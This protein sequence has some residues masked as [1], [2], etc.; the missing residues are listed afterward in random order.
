MIRVVFLLQREFSEECVFNEMIEENHYNSYSSS[1]YSNPRRT[2]YLGLNKKGQG[3]RVMTRGG[4]LGRQS[5][6]A[7]VLT[8][9]VQWQA[10]NSTC[11][12]DQPKAARA[13]PPRCRLRLRRPRRRK[14]K[15]CKDEESCMRKRK[16][17]LRIRH[18]KHRTVT[19]EEEED[20]EE[21]TMTTE[22]EEEDH[23]MDSSE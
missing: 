5:A 20:E 7:R 10:K 19:E 11:P 4:A 12:R 18:R 8:Q 17:R 15:R 1:K 9:P 13:G 16:S 14:R 21:V 2:L 3:R 23:T 22:E 6:F